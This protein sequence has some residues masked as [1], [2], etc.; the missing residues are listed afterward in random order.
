MAGAATAASAAPWSDAERAAILSLGPWPPA[1]HSDPSNRVSGQPGAVALGEN[2]FASARVSANGSVRCAACHE[3]WRSF[4]DG[5]ATALGL[6]PG[7]RNT[8]S[9]WN[10]AWQRWFGWDGAADS[11]W[12]QSL[13]ALVDATEMGAS[14]AHAAALVRGDM[15]LRLLYQPVFG[16]VDRAGDEELLVNLAK[17]L[18]AFQETLVSP[19]TPFDAYRDALAARNPVAESRYP[20]PARAGLA[21]FIGKGGCVTCHSGPLLSDGAFHRSLLVSAP[22]VEPDGGRITGLAA[23]GASRYNLLGPYS[24]ARDDAVSKG[25]RAALAAPQRSTGFRTPSLREVAASAPYMHDGRVAGLCAAVAAH[26]A[27]DPDAAGAAQAHAAQALTLA[28]RRSLAAFL[29]TLSGNKAFVEASTA[30]DCS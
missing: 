13:H 19:R 21:L 29:R 11:L 9:L 30:N 20:R 5:R 26:A 18:A 22:G 7:R 4:T 1:P 28:E 14:A 6:A 17:A 24:D 10:V 15:Q 25:T 12:A 2:L 23:L 16:D 8:L 3:P 27:P